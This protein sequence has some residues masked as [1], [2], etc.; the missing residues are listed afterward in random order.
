MTDLAR[1]FVG[2]DSSLREVIACIDRNGKGIALVVD[3]DQRLIGTITDG[4]VRRALLA[5]RDLDWRAAALLAE[6]PPQA[7]KPLTAPDDTAAAELLELMQRHD[8]RHI[9][10]VQSENRVVGV[11]LLS[12]LIEEYRLPIRAVIMA[13]GFG[14]R[15][16]PLTDET[17]KA[18]LPIGDRPL[19]EHIVRQLKDVGIR[20]LSLATHYRGDTIRSHFGD[21]REFDVEIQYVDEGEPLGT[22]GALS[23]LEGSD[24]PLLVMNGDILTRVDFRAM[25]EFHT[26]S[27]AEL[28]MAVRP[29]ELQVPYGVVET[30]GIEVVRLAEKPVARYLINA[31]IYLLSPDIQR[32]VPSGQRYDMTDLVS[33]L[34]ADGR[35]VISFPVRE[36]WIDIGHHEDYLRARQSSSGGVD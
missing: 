19:L 17:P 10:L 35:R 2:P 25:L 16:R 18:M 33:R 32:R 28:T 13:G 27:R 20:R 31:G 5:G 14:T 23:L 11:A 36:S 30:N 1:Y 29:F 4:D 6:K 8:V 3:A 24:E 15:L 12:D 21:G 26:S 22:A 7:L 9:P 34:I